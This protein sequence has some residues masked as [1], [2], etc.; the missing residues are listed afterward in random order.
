MGA[1]GP[2]SVE[3]LVMRDTTEDD[4]LRLR[5]EDMPAHLTDAEEELWRRNRLFL[6]LHRVP[7][8][9]EKV[10]NREIRVWHG[11]TEKGP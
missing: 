8:G 2:V 9:D 4:A 6:N 11:A 3:L 7:Y 1:K 5:D 10:A